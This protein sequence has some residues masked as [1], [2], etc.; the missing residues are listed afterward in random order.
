LA[1]IPTP[2]SSSAYFN[3]LF[4]LL[5]PQGEGNDPKDG[6]TFIPFSCFLFPSFSLSPSSSLFS[7]PYLP[8]PSFLHHPPPLL[9]FSPPSSPPSNF[10]PRHFPLFAISHTLPLY[11]PLPTSPPTFFP[12]FSLPPTLPH[13][14]PPPLLPFPPLSSISLTPFPLSSPP[15]PLFSPSIFSPSFLFFLHPLSVFSPSTLFSFPLPPLSLATYFLCFLLFPPPLLVSLS[16]HFSRPHHPFSPFFFSPP[17]VFLL[18]F[19]LF[20]FP[21][22]LFFFL[23]LFFGFLSLFC[24]DESGFWFY[25]LKK[26]YFTTESQPT[27]SR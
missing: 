10:S 20:F 2:K 24:P 18:P 22:P 12:F 9:F 1:C 23:L 3:V 16:A 27:D 13:L 17:F 7:P 19:L 15:S 5:T 4:F 26:K 11:T 6:G 8:F 25:P 14:P 21:S